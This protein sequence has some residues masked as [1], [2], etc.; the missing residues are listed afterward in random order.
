MTDNKNVISSALD[1]LKLT[2]ILA[3]DFEARSYSQIVKLVKSKG[4]EISQT[5]IHNMLTTLESAGWVN[6]DSNELWRLSTHFASLAVNY[7]TY[8][9]RRSNQLL[10]EVAEVHGTERINN[11]AN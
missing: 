9:I 8:I 6:R 11:N 2:E 10:H 5:K 7:H 3:E 4:L 1:L